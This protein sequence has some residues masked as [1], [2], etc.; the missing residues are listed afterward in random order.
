MKT[1]FL[2]ITMALVAI[3][4][5]TACVNTARVNNSGGS[6]RVITGHQTVDR[7]TTT[8]APEPVRIQPD[9]GTWN[10]TSKASAYA[11]AQSWH[12]PI[13]FKPCKMGTNGAMGCD[14]DLTWMTEVECQRFFAGLGTASPYCGA[15]WVKGS[16]APVTYQEQVP[17]EGEV[18]Q[19]GGGDVRIT[20][21]NHVETGLTAVFNGVFGL[22]GQLLEQASYCPP[23]QR[24]A[25]QQRRYCPPPRYAQQQQQSGRTIIRVHN[26]NV[27]NNR[28]NNYLNPQSQGRYQNGSYSNGGGGSRAGYRGGNPGLRYY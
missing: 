11:R 28:N 26:N 3:F 22:T 14:S 4:T 5:T 6:R 13:L 7:I 25:Q 23:Q 16:L 1:Q 24:Y 21:S 10:G 12:G 18:D 20:Q 17:I 8:P 19:E 2:K 15:V 9:P 27:N